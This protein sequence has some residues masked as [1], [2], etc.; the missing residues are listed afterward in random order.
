MGGRAAASLQLEIAIHVTVKEGRTERAIESN[1]EIRPT[2]E[3]GFNFQRSTGAWHTC[4]AEKGT[5]CMTEWR[6]GN[7]VRGR[8]QRQ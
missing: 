8:V 4:E 3:R 5:F 6:E 2:A 7:A 1:W